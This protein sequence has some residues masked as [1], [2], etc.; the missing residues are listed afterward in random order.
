MKEE[1][2][3]EQLQQLKKEFEERKEKE[4][5]QLCEESQ[6]MEEKETDDDDEIE[7][8]LVLNRGSKTNS[9][10]EVARTLGYSNLEEVKKILALRE[11]IA[12]MN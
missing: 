9:E 1:E 8:N 5:I 10:E 7:E 4:S 11:Y 2:L 12:T 3:L 6:I